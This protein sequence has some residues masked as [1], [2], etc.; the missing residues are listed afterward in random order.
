MEVEPD[1][2][3]LEGGNDLTEFQYSGC[4][5][6]GHSTS[7]VTLASAGGAPRKS[8]RSGNADSD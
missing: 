1:K 6:D 8:K 3:A 5:L 2:R 4:M 7:E